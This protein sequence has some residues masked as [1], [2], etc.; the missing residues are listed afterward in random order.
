MMY[1]RGHRIG[2]EPSRV[3]F[4][5]SNSSGEWDGRRELDGEGILLA[6]PAEVAINS[7]RG[8]RGGGY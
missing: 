1:F 6:A 3:S 2:G 5:P 4:Q 8:V 7:K